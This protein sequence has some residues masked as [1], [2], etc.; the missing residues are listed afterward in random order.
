MGIQ[1]GF[2][3]RLRIIKGKG[4]RPRHVLAHRRRGT[5]M[6]LDAPID[7][8]ADYISEQLPWLAAHPALVALVI[9]FG[10]IILF[11]LAECW[12]SRRTRNNRDLR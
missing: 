1:P 3:S 9:V 2:D 7:A 5:P 10:P 4:L 8:L 11:A 6:D 12:L